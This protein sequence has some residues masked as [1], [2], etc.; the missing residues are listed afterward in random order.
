M[1]GE[2][3]HSRWKVKSTSYMAVAREN[4]VCAR[5]LPF[6]K[7]SDL[8]RLNHYH[9][10]STGKTWPHDSIIS[11]W[12]L[13]DNYRPYKMRFGWGHRVKHISMEHILKKK[14]LGRARWLKPVIPALWKAKAGGSLKAR[15]SRSA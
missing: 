14:N 11:H 12:V 9:K 1:A 8:M 6:V 13:H 4:R 15:S 3:S 10:N 2:S 7:L 5:K